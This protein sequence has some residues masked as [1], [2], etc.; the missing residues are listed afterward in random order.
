[1]KS[2]FVSPSFRK[3]KKDYSERQAKWTVLFK[4]KIVKSINTESI[5]YKH[6]NFKI[7]K[8]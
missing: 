2:I 8:F 4:K 7:K 5:L 1:M 6:K 3:K